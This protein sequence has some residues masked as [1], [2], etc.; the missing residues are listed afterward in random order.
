MDVPEIKNFIVQ[1]EPFDKLPEDL[2]IPPGAFEII[3]EAFEGPLDLLLYLIKKQN[4]DILNIPIALITKQYM[5]Y[6]SL[7]EIIPAAGKA[8][9]SVEKVTESNRF[10]LAAEYLVMAAML[11]EIKSQMLLPKNPMAAEEEADPRAE[12]A[13]R[14]LEYEQYKKAAEQLDALP[15]Q[16]RDF[17]NVN[18]KS[19]DMSV[20]SDEQLNDLRPLASVTLE[21]LMS[22]LEDVMAR[23]KNRAHHHVRRESLTVSDRIEHILT[24]LQHQLSLTSSHNPVQFH[25][26]LTFKEG[27]MGV[28]VTFMAILELVKQSVIELIQGAPFEPISIRK[29]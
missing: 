4:L 5:E 24:H 14:L 1:G 19:V 8:E 20:I 6:I 7:M 17:F 26:F 21:S 25:V 23:L 13:R 9:D 12:L 28:V 22:A 3:L 18:R 2:Y 16:D 29:L 15:R 10:E 27:R 11:A